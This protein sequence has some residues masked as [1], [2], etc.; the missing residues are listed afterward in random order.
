MRRAARVDD[1]QHEL[2]QL[3]VAVGG[4]WTPLPPGTGRDKGRP[5]GVWGFRG[6]T[7]LAEVKVPG[8]DPRPEQVEWH[9]RWRGSAVH[10]WRT[11]ED[12]MRSLGLRH[13]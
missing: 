12:V 11:R 8:E 3:L 1:N 9:R 2:V 4:S 13:R 10:V 7:G 5:D 6:M